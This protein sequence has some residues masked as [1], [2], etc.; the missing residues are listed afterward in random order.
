[1]FYLDLKW[2]IYDHYNFNKIGQRDE[3]ITNKKKTFVR[4]DKIPIN[5]DNHIRIFSNNTWVIKK[6][7]LIDF[8][9][10]NPSHIIWQVHN[11]KF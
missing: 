10:R 4:E 11:K 1:M 8:F 5:M 6:M 2:I 3:I 7:Y 9:E